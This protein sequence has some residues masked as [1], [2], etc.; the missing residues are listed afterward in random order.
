MKPMNK[1]KEEFDL[2][3]VKV[4]RTFEGF[5][6]EAVTAILLVVTWIISFTQHQFEGNMQEEWKMGLIVLTVAIIVVLG[7]VYYPRLLSNR[8]QL[9]NIRQVAITIRMNRVIALE[10]AL[11][12][13]CNAIMGC[14]LV[15]QVSWMFVFVIIVLIT[16]L[17]FSFLIYKAK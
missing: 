4:T 10:L 13:F 9:S 17:V 8:H 7:A 6:F 16:V 14:K 5:I 11:M 15:Q 1:E 12:V 2:K 3:E